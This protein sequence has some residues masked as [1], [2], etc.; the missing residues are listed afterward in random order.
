MGLE[1][2]AVLDKDSEGNKIDKELSEKSL[3]EQDR[4]I[5]VS[6][7]DGFAIE[8]LFTQDDFNNY[9]LEETQK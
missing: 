4:V 3:I 5:F 7:Q 9:V 6:E 8:D 2:L 1:F